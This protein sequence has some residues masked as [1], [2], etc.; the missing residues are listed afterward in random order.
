LAT[1]KRL[2]EGHRGRV[3]VCSEPGR[4]STFW[5]VLPHAGSPDAANAM[6][7]DEADLHEGHH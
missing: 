1:V 3:G 7:T 6:S 5:F 4:G 2:V